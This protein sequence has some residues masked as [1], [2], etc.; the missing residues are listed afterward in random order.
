MPKNK[1]C[2][3]CDGPLSQGRCL[4]QF[5][6]PIRCEVCVTSSVTRKRGLVGC[7]ACSGLGYG[8]IGPCRTCGGAGSRTCSACRGT[9]WSRR[10]PVRPDLRHGHLAIDWAAL[11]KV[12][13]DE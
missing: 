9:G 8:P 7:S 13:A 6:E 5:T 3:V 10:R 2:T 4:T 12:A 11:A 1:T